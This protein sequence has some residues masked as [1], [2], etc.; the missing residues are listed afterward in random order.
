MHVYSMKPYRPFGMTG[1]FKHVI[2]L[3]RQVRGCNPGFHTTMQPIYERQHPSS[4]GH[5]SFGKSYTDVLPDELARLNL[6][7]VIIVASK[8]LAAKSEAVT[9]LEVT[10]GSRYVAAKIGVGANR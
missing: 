5:V 3:F 2:P 10:L 7:R 4:S 8:S 1:S 6:S 9:K